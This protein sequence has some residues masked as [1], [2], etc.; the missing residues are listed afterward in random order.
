MDLIFCAGKNPTFAAIAIAAGFR[1]GAQLPCATYGPVWFADQNWKRPDR[2]RYMQALA[3]ERPH[4]ATV[5]DWERPEQLPEVLGWA[6]DAAS[7]VE[8]VL[9]IPK[10]ASWSNP[11]DRLPRRIGH[12]QVVAAYSVPTRHGGTDLPIRSFAGWPVHLLGGS[13]HEQMRLARVFAAHGAMVVSVD[14]NMHMRQANLLGAFW[15]AEKGRKGHWVQLSEV[16]DGDFGRDSNVEA[17]RRSCHNI[18]D[19]WRKQG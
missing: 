1:Y 11:L 17:F 5:L 2:T 16:G 10:L 9:I 7:L 6:E 19:A 18:M 15:R 8:R 4:M 14:G 3:A 12:A 13:P